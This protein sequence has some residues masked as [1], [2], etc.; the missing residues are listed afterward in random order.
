MWVRS[1]GR[2]DPQRRKWQSTPVFLEWKIP[3]TEE[4]GGL[5]STGWQKSWTQLSDETTCDSIKR[6]ESGINNVFLVPLGLE[7]RRIRAGLQTSQS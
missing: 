1:P 7:P 6:A 5:Q 2:E 4:S 3:W